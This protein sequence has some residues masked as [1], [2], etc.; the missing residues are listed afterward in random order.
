M[1]FVD[2][3]AIFALIDSADKHHD[4]AK[5]QITALLDGQAV[6]LTHNYV[7]LECTSLAQKRL[8]REIAAAVEGIAVDF[9]ID[10][11]DAGQ[12]NEAVRRWARRTGTVSLV[13]EVS[14]LVMRERGIDTAFAFDA[15]FRREGFR[16]L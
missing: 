16:T 12:H 4:R 7:L 13:D 9:D 3:S 1:I 15:H 14:F 2:T 11:I 6:L 5:T 8:G 10:W